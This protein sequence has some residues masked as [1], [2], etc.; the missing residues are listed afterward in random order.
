MF[1]STN[2]TAALCTT[3]STVTSSFTT[4]PAA[5]VTTDDVRRHGSGDP[6][7]TD[8]E[9][10]GCTRSNRCD[11]AHHSKEY[12]EASDVVNEFVVLPSLSVASCFKIFI[13][14]IL[15]REPKLHKPLLG[16]K[17]PD[18]EASSDDEALQPQES[19]QRLPSQSPQEDAAPSIAITTVDA[20]ESHVVL[21]A[22]FTAIRQRPWIRSTYTPVVQAVPMNPLGTSL[23]ETRSDE[24]TTTLEAD[25]AS[26]APFQRA[27]C[28]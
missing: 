4:A 14:Q 16:I 12:H 24:F 23:A 6:V 26:A 17:S 13:P 20:L 25:P 5:C 19:Q 22:A 10:G 8:P 9:A 7:R 18:Q 27:G 21:K 1:W 3:V 28:F 11:Y 15:W 2:A